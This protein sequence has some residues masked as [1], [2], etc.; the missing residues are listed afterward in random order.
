VVRGN[1]LFGRKARLLEFTRH[2]SENRF[3]RS[4]PGRCVS[5]YSRL[6][7]LNLPAGGR[8]PL[9]VITRLIGANMARAE[10]T[11]E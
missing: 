6:T 9:H 5:E 4:Y 11:T 1:V 10:A 3:S 2:S 8:F 7:R